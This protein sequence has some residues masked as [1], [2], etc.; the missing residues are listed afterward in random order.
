MYD[1]L[2]ATIEHVPQLDP[3]AAS[4]L[5]LRCCSDPGELPPSGPTE[6]SLLCPGEISQS[7]EH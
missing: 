2:E 3:P 4:H 7:A 1:L 5:L 6:S